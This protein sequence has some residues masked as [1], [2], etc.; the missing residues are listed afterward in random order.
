[1]LQQ[2]PF[3]VEGVRLQTHIQGIVYLNNKTPLEP[4]RNK[5]FNELQVAVGFI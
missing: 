1:M 5:L 4:A 2:D 3:E